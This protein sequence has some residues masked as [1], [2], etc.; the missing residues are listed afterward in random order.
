MTYGYPVGGEIRRWELMR[1]CDLS[2]S[3][4]RDEAVKLSR[5]GEWHLGCQLGAVTAV[6]N[7]HYLAL[8]VRAREQV[9]AVIRDD[10]ADLA[11][12]PRQQPL[13]LRLQLVDTVAC[14]GRHDDRLALSQL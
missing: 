9:T 12:L 7:C 1:G 14:L 5:Q 2:R 4:R 8:V 3:I 11:E 13:D 10:D 6:L